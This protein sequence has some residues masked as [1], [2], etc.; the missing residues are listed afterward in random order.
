VVA[1]IVPLLARTGPGSGA[2]AVIAR[3]ADPAPLAPFKIHQEDRVQQRIRHCQW[4]TVWLPALGVAMFAASVAALAALDAALPAERWNMFDLQVY[5]WAGLVIRRSGDLYGSHFPTHHLSFTYPPMAALI[6]AVLSAEPMSYLKWLVT[7]AS[8]A[9]LAAAL[10]LTLG[11]LGYQRS[12]G[13]LAAAL[14]ATGIA[15]WLQPTQDTLVFG[16][17]NL[18]LMLIIL[19]DLCLP[20]TAWFK[21][22]GV[23]LAAGFKLTPLI[24][25]PYLVL[26]RRFRAAGV[27]LAT[28]TLTIVGSLILLPGQAARFWFG[29]V[30]LN[31]NRAGN[32]AYVGNQSL[33]GALERLLGGQTVAQPYWLACS[34]LAG[35]A[36]LLLAARAAR[37]GDE[38]TGV[39]ICALTGLLVSPI[40]W[41]HHWVWAAPA[42]LV[43][44]DRAHR[45]RWPRG[46][47]WAAWCGVA[48]LAAPFCTL[49]E[50]L[51]PA[52]VVQGK[53]AN[54]PE[55]VIGDLYV[56]TGLAALFVVGLV[57][58][59]STSFSRSVDGAEPAGGRR[60][61]RPWR[62]RWRE[63]P[64]GCFR[65]PGGGPARRSL[66]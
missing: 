37:R 17:V 8:I 44:A 30:S 32:N 59:S 38:I 21:G 11:A 34:V 23:G 39:L 53:G 58:A 50:V 13:R 2:A 3:Q 19:A 16:Q 43:A 10:W 20:D 26:T 9:C 36:G 28:F 18:I 60:P 66:R 1:A 55:L 27:A 15:L 4:M 29:G 54:G 46:W 56:I 51:V 64:P 52:S 14:A 42:L 12:A 22:I 49:P 41:S 33:H 24:F 48:A 7:V 31:S 47:R 65:P 57:L 62:R 45:G 61:R 35:A 63:R 6:F 25:V 5:R 40:S